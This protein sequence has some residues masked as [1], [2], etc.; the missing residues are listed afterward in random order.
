MPTSITVPIT[1]EE[2]KA[3]LTDILSLQDWLDNAIRNKARQCIDDV[4]R[5]ALEDETNTVLTAAEKQGIV[6]ALATQGRIIT[7][8]KQL[9]EAVKHQIVA[10]AR[11]KSAAERQ[12]EQEKQPI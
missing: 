2:E 4:C 8:V 3:L 9:P 6:S 12:A 11:V 10:A 5:Q 7:T 1:D